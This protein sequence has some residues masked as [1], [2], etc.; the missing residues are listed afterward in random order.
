MG[1]QDTLEAIVEQMP[2]QR[3]TLL[4]SATYPEAIQFI[5]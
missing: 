2:V 5:A 3:Q 1:F 4:F